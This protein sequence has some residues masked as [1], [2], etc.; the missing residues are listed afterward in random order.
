MLSACIMNPRSTG[1][2]GLGTYMSFSLQVSFEPWRGVGLG[3]GGP[4]C[5]GFVVHMWF[6]GT[7]FGL[8]P[9][10]NFCGLVDLG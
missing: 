10:L 8:V 4:F 1:F 6:V 5:I 7:C 3:H 9:S 2:L